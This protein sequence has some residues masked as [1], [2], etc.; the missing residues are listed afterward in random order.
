MAGSIAHRLRRLK[1]NLLCRLARAAPPFTR[2]LPATLPL[3]TVDYRCGRPT[4]ALVVFLPGITDIAE[5]FEHQGFIHAMRERDIAADAVALDAHYGYYAT[6]TI[7]DR[8]T[9]EV[10]V[11]AQQFGYE[12]IWLVG[13]S[14]GGLGALSYAARHPENVSGLVLLAPYLGET[15][16]IN[17]IRTTGGIAQ[18]SP[19]VIDEA[20]YQRMLWRWIKRYQAAPLPNLPIYLG[21]GEQDSFAAANQLLAAVLPGDHVVTV[22]GGHNWITWK[23]LWRKLLAAAP[24]GSWT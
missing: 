12:K 5:D 11:P 17:E 16:V 18:W 23:K 15:A 1:R 24:A 20:D 21:F 22:H 7:H 10:I 3:A 4:S 6:R 14:L 2:L 9:R 19:T 13:I 8:L